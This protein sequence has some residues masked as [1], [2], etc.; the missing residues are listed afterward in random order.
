MGEQRR[1]VRFFRYRIPLDGV[2]WLDENTH[3]MSAETW[4]EYD[5]EGFDVVLVEYGPETDWEP[6]VAAEVNGDGT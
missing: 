3:V 6:N 5:D 2:L 1:P 4:S